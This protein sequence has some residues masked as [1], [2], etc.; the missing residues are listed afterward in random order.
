[1]KQHFQNIMDEEEATI[2]MTPMLD[3]VFIML[4][5]F[6]VTASFVKEAGI[7]VNR[8]DAATAVKKDRANILIAIS[9]TGEIWINKRRIDARA[10][11]ANIERLH[12]ENPQGT[13]VIQADKKATTE[14]L[15]KVMDASRSAGVYDVSIAAQE[16]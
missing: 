7:D 9:E 1:M 12:A 14:V 11:Q 5:F 13:V 16:P 15:I 4:I 6:I 2:D 3:V 8:P 10:V